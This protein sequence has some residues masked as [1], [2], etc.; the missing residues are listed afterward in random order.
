[1]RI[2][3]TGANGF[4][5]KHLTNILSV[6]NYQVTGSVRNKTKNY[7][8]VGDI[9]ENTDWSK[10]LKNVDV[11]IHLANRAHIMDDKSKN[12]EQ[13]FFKINVKG[14]EKL[15]QD[16]KNT[17]VKQIIY[18]SSIKVNGERTF[19][20]PFYYDDV[21]SK[22][23]DAYSY[24]KYEAE[25]I[26]Q[27]LANKF[28]INWTIIRPPLVYGKG[29]KGNF[30]LLLNLIKKGIPLP[31]ASI[32]NKR[33]FIGVNNLCDLIMTCINNKKAYSQT[34][35]ASDNN[36]LS[37]S[38]LAYK[39]ASVINKKVI[40]FSFP[41][42]LLKFLAKIFAKSSQIDRLSQSLRLNITRTIERLNWQVPYS[43]KKELK[44]L[45]K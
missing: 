35:L 40:V 19:D 13:E 34:F 21:I 37:T 23:E 6:N 30:Q 8:A 16:A 42:F 28:N 15:I 12:P 18:L 22:P 5:G 25:K 33:S 44:S 39:I 11:I 31:F 17:K 29:V 20:K 32:N 43:V 7:I 41:V 10:A 3:V 1:M 14:F 36:D 24:S 4:I 2:L 9:D 26:L 45:M 38:E 27:K